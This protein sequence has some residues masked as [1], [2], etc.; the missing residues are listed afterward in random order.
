M[1]RSCRNCHF[2]CYQSNAVLGIGTSAEPWYWRYG[3]QSDKPRDALRSWTAEEREKGMVDN[4]KSPINKG[5]C[6]K[7]VWA[8]N[9]DRY[10]DHEQ[11]GFVEG[12]QQAW[13]RLVKND[14]LLSDPVPR[15]NFS[16]RR[17]IDKRRR[18]CF[19]TPFQTG[20][21]LTSAA[22]ME[23]RTHRSKEH[24]KTRVIAWLALLV[25][26]VST[27]IGFWPTAD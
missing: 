21:E 20:Q 16:L 23:S 13:H 15:A 14:L 6:F 10:E 2:L 4:A 26:I 27:I 18:S 12:F 22:E 7:G 11:V 25:S 24:T 5:M 8:A 19:W 17:Q 1:T 3:E 9:D